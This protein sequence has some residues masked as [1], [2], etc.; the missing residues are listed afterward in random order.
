MT[1]SFIYENVDYGEVMCSPQAFDAAKSA[2]ENKVLM[3]EFFHAVEK[4]I[5]QQRPE[6]NIE[7]LF[8][9]AGPRAIMLL[10]GATEEEAEQYPIIS[11]NWLKKLGLT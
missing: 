1:K 11:S 6:W 10:L 8:D 4:H 5:K 3:P 7:R 9:Y 2:K